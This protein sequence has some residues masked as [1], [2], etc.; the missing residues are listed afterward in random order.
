MGTHGEI[1]I[2]YLF[3]NF[4][5]DLVGGYIYVWSGAFSKREALLS[6]VQNVSGFNGITRTQFDFAPT[7]G[8]VY[9]LHAS[10]WHLGGLIRSMLV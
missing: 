5:S 2:R 7:N 1:N 9:D 6:P 8:C 3:G 4:N 10:Q